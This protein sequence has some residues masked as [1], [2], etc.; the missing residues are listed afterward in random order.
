[1]NLTTYTFKGKGAPIL[2]VAEEALGAGGGLVLTRQE[3]E[4]LLRQH[5]EALPFDVM[6]R[7]YGEEDGNW[8]GLT[9]EDLDTS[10]P[11]GQQLDPDWGPFEAWVFN[12]PLNVASLKPAAAPAPEACPWCGE[13][14]LLAKL[15]PTYYQPE[16]EDGEERTEAKRPKCGHAIVAVRVLVFDR[17]EKAA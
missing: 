13:P 7:N 9:P 16:I 1:M 2:I 8:T 3:A 11:E 4:R 6:A 15:D 17:I 5:G 10:E 14:D 12:A